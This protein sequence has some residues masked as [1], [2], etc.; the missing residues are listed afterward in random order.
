LYICFQ[1]PPCRAFTPQLAKAYSAIKADNKP[2]EIIFLSSDRADESFKSYLDTMP[3]YAV[4]YEDSLRKNNVSKHFGVEG[5]HIS[6]LIAK[7]MVFV[8]TELWPS[9]SE[10]NIVTLGHVGSA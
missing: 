4:P 7:S 10:I 5:K 3:W 2:F 1:C 8:F 9:L 6:L